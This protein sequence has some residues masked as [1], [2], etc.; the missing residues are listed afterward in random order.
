MCKDNDENYAIPPS[1]RMTRSA[2]Q[3][4][5]KKLQHAS[6]RHDRDHVDFNKHAFQG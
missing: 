4:G 3:L 6:L 1:A 5:I 2:A